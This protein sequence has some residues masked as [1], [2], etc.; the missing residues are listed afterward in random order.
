MVIARRVHVSGRPIT[1]CLINFDGEQYLPPALEAA[2]PH[3]RFSEILLIDNASTDGSVALVRARFPHVRIVRLA[4]NR[5]P[6]AAR[7]AGFVAAAC[8]LILFQDNDVQLTADCPEQLVS[9]LERA[10]GALLV[11]P[12]VLYRHDPERVQYDSA[13]CH[14]LGLMTPRHANEHAAIAAAQ[15]ASTTSLVTACFLLDRARWRGASLFDERFGFNLEDHDFGVRACVSGH[16]LRVEPRARVLHAGGTVGLSFR[17]GGVVHARRVYYLIRNRWYV[18]TKVFAAR[19]LLLLAPVLLLFELNQLAGALY[20]GWLR[21]W[22]AAVR[23]YRRELPRLLRERHAVQASRR[24]GDRALL[25]EGPLPLTI[26]VNSTRAERVAVGTLQAIV[27][28]YWRLVR[29]LV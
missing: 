12:R 3:A 14:V 1:L 10:P 16:E 5:G 26:A 21:C 4:E 23:D 2:E 15:S 24:I 13:D 19:T 9:A 6:A 27:S 28:A 11:A 25:R 18:I 17:P 8:E 7:N 22:W 29:P 20:K